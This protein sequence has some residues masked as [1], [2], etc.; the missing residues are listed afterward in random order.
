MDECA[1]RGWRVPRF[2]L[3]E[4][5]PRRTKYCV[6]IPIINEGQRII[7]QLRR[8]Q[9]LGIPQL[10]DIL[11]LDGGSTDGC[12][13]PGR[14]KQLGVRTLLTKRGPGKQ[15]AQ[16]RMGYAYAMLEGYEGI[17]GIDGNGK[18][19]VDS[20]RAF[21]QELEAGWDLIQGSRYLPGGAAV[22]TPILR[23]IAIKLI[24]V[25]IVRMA[26][27]FAYTDTTNAYRGYS[28]R[29]L[30]D[31]R[32]NPFRDVFM[33]YELLAYLSVRAPQLGFK[34]KEIPVRREYPADG[35]VPTKIS[36]FRGNLLLLRILWKTLRG[37]YNP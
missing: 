33:T 24:H 36:H 18:D 9:D 17:V 13:E 23:S 31:E 2:E 35:T 10:A 14:L 22:R 3:L 1:A 4:L 34:T 19:S 16:H 37:A 27:G 28:R 5:A 8:M 32:V 15:A 7:D 21:I 25:P 6:C 20:I 30:L 26:G 29:F 11:I 12:T